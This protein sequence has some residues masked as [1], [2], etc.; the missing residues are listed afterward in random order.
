MHIIYLELKGES[1]IDIEHGD[2]YR[3]VAFDPRSSHVGF[4]VN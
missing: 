1:I 4:S 3:Y 2:D